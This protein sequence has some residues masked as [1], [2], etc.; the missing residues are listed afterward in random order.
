MRVRTAEFDRTLRQYMDLSKRDWAQVFN[1]KGFF[2]AR[3]ATVD[4]KKADPAEIRKLRERRVIGTGSK[5]GK[6]VKLRDPLAT[7]RAALILQ[8]RRRAQGEPAI[9]KRDLPA[10]VRKFIGA[11]LRSVAYLKSGWLPAIGTL[12]P[13]A[14]VRAK[15]RMDKS[16]KVLKRPKGGAK[17][18]RNYWRTFCQIFN[19]A[20]TKRNGDAGLRRFGQA[21]LQAAFDAEVRSM[22][23]YIERKLTARAQRLGIRTR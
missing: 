5:N 1:T 20:I 10:A 2:I 13:L 4:T 8:A 6:V 12:E 9:P 18:A 17:P 23:E 7:T 19:A 15:P 16:G 14:D 11:R 21:G 22:K 3:R